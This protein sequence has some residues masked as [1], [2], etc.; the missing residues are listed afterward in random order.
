[1]E[2][3]LLFQ[4]VLLYRNAQKHASLGKKNAVDPA[5]PAPK[6]PPPLLGRRFFGTADGIRTH[7]LFRAAREKP[8]AD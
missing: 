4:F 8:P 6:K 5:D 1:M 7:D 2:G 3:H